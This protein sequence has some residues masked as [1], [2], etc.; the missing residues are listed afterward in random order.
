MSN[1]ANI[2]N[3]DLFSFT[4][5]TSAVNMIP[6]KPHQLGQWFNWNGQGVNTTSIIVEELEGRLAVIPS[7]ARGTVGKGQANPKRK[8]RSFVIPHYPHYDVIK[9][10]EVQGVRAFGSS[11]EFETVEAKLAEK[12][13]S[14]RDNHDVTEEFAKA[15]A[16]SGI[17]RDADGSVI[18]DWHQ[19]FKVSRNTHNID[20]T[21][22]SIN[23]RDELIAAKR[24]GEKAIG[25][26]L[27]YSGWKLVCTPTI[28]SAI[29]SHPSIVA[30]YE[31]WQDG[32]FLRAD[33]RKGFMIA[34][35]IEVVSYHNN[36]VGSVE[37]ITEGESYLV[38]NSQ[39][40][41]QS[42][43]A[44]ADTMEAANTIGLPLY[45][46][47]EPMDFGRGVD[48]ATEQNAIYYAVLPK[49]IVQIKQK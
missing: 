4:S 21:D 24:K 29:T 34:D 6:E 11:S 22:V 42:R 13:V 25:G 8:A 12:Y 37:F 30:A 31:R 26:T 14:M 28:F 48:L 1:L 18:Y 32:A 47:S 36:T 3:S 20:F 43:F 33:N 35:D 17:L 41:F 44:P 49:A 19:E 38:P 40:L 7:A 10:I 16:I 15:G 2:F 39:N 46:M 45:M 23:L 9:A 5:L 27:L